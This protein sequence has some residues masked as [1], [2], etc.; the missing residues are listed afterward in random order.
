M[1]SKVLNRKHRNARLYFLR[2]SDELI[3]C[4]VE[5][6]TSS[7]ALTWSSVGLIRSSVEF[8]R[9]LVDLIDL[10]GVLEHFMAKYLNICDHLCCVLQ[11]LA[12]IIYII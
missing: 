7:L 12:Q 6:K 4:I 2:S 3:R 10:Y 5:L 9:D 11:Y 1:G 8:R